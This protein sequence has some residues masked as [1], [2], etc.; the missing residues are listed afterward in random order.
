MNCEILRKDVNRM[1]NR[2]LIVGEDH[3]D[4]RIDGKK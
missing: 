1:V 2:T 3:E 4:G